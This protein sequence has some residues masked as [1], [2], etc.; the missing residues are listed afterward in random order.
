V[1][2]PNLTI[3]NFFIAVQLCEVRR[4]RSEEKRFD[5]VSERVA[6]LQDRQAAAAGA[7]PLL[8]PD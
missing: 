1:P 6:L 4:Q 3:R 8:Q 2:N 5:A 7:V